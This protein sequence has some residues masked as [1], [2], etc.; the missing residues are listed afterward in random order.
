MKKK[1]LVMLMAASMVCASLSGCGESNTQA[2]VSV[3]FT[4]ADDS[5]GEG[6]KASTETATEETTE[7]AESVVAE[8]E[9]VETVYTVGVTSV[10]DGQIIAC[11]ADGNAYVL[12]LADN[13]SEEEAALVAE[14]S[15]LNVTETAEAGEEKVV[16]AYTSVGDKALVKAYTINITAVALADDETLVASITGLYFPETEEEAAY[17]VEAIEAK[18]MYA[19]QSV[20]VRSGPSSDYEKLG[21]LSWAQE[22]A[23]TGVADTGWYQIG[24]NGGIAYV[25]DSYLVET[26]PE[27]QVASANTNSGASASNGAASNSGSTQNG[28]KYVKTISD[29]S[30]ATGVDENQEYSDATQTSSNDGGNIEPTICT[31]F[32]G[33]VNALRDGLRAEGKRAGTYNVEWDDSLALTA[34]ERAKE[35]TTDFSHNGSRNSSAEI[36]QYTYESSSSEWYQNF[37]DSPAHYG[38][39][40][41]I[42]SKIGAAYCEVDGTYY[43]VVLFD[44]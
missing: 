37:Y 29:W 35:L 9:K 31:D 24:Y 13:L 14:G 44:Y 30:D 28:V 1:L 23:V 19:K 38:T 32:V 39:M 22:V 42:G 7:E 8:P 34:L 12:A 21:S 41:A 6:S 11:D 27:K 15:I 2:D 10:T 33:Y 25:S 43:I 3:E 16:G 5:S 4:G 20:N 18:S 36:I 17:T 40:T 26:K